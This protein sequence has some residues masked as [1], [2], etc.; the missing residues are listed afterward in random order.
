MMDGSKSARLDDLSKL[1][2]I[3]DLRKHIAAEFDVEP[4][5]QRLFYRGK[6][7]EDGYKLFDYDVG[8]NDIIQMMV[9]STAA[10]SPKAIH[11][12]KKG[13]ESGLSLQ[14][15]SET[16]NSE[17]PSVRPKEG[18]SS[19]CSRYYKVGD[20]VDARD[21]NY[22]GWFEAKIVKITRKDDEEK[23]MEKQDTI[24]DDGFLYHVQYDGYD[25]DEAATFGLKSIRPRACTLVPFEAIK[26]GDMVMVNYNT[27]QPEELGFWY[28]CR[29]TSKRS[30][31]TI[32]EL[33]GTVFLGTSQAPLENCKIK[34]CNEI[35]A[36]EG[37][38]KV[39]VD[40][41]DNLP[42]SPV[43]RTSKPECERCQDNPSRQCRHCSCC[44]CGG[45][46]KPE[47]QIMCD[48]CNNAFHLWC[49]DPPLEDIPQDDDW[50]CP[51]CKTD[52][53]EV[54]KAGERLKESKK[55]ARMASAKQERTARDWGKGMACVGRTR[56]C[57]LV[58][59]NH[60]GAIP[61]VEV[62]TQWKFRVQ[63]SESG[64]HRPHVAG[65]HGRDGEGAFS[66]VL[67]G[68]YEDDV[69]EGDEFMY[70][71]SGGRDLSG[72]KRT[73]EQSCDQM[74]TRMNKALALNCAASLNDKSGAEA[75]DWR[76]GKPVRV[77]RNCKGR[78]HSKYCPEEGNR[79]DGIYKVVKYW[80]EKGKSGFLV[81]R[82]LLRR[83]D[84]SPAPWTSAG[85]KR[86]EEL[87]LTMQYPEGYLEA[88]SEKKGDSECENEDVKKKG[89]GKRPR[90]TDNPEASPA[91]RKKAKV[92]TYKVDAK[93]QSKID[94]DTAN[95][96]LWQECFEFTSNGQRA[97]LQKVEE[98]F[99]CICC[100]EIV[101]DPITTP[102]SHNMCKSCMQRSFKADVYTCPMCR[103]DLGKDY[104]VIVNT[105]LGDVLKSLFP[106]Y[107]K[108]R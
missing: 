11:G 27:E 35:F 63:V 98:L 82:Y 31:R 94:K 85:K 25:D 93:V 43:K 53:T 8:L 15:G 84:S 88:Q 37:H 9:R 79:Y 80:P 18:T 58:P 2:K 65:I 32:K 29:V 16:V 44:R 24:E 89:R 76:A 91:P 62:G 48:E 55:K 4:S 10:E 28:D 12:A 106:G 64:V 81:W 47:K 97:F 42:Q 45:K 59:P 83:D 96:K 73:A 68:G 1:T 102:C 54:V 17:I 100:Q 56:E 33:R 86:S 108:G 26:V 71:G 57:T 52:D 36:I 87:G 46:D 95:T 69:D 60:L 104:K 38:P 103:N 105:L 41:R 22:G 77:V 7:L 5:L 75:K 78:K 107:E 70:T 92:A 51:D 40:Q 14:P 72:N 99:G 20:L 61:G 74:L 39:A 50:F 34:F 66:I 49:L 23:R 67:S 90:G 30:T 13:E 101:H 21:I 19:V 3:E 6:Q